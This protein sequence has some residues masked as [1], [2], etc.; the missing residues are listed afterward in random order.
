MMRLLVEGKGSAGHMPMSRE[1]TLSSSPNEDGINLDHGTK[2]G[3]SNH[4][5]EEI[6]WGFASL[7]GLWH[8]E[9]S[10]QKSEVAPPLK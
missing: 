1:S 5:E 2:F 3:I 6:H 7:T 4:H 9:F 10:G 8:R